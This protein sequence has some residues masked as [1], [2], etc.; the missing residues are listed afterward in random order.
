MCEIVGFVDASPSGNRYDRSS[1]L[2]LKLKAWPSK[3][4]AMSIYGYER[5][6]GPVVVT[7]PLPSIADIS[8]LREKIS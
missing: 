3:L 7:S 8:N 1:I 2:P 6:S 4:A 5:K